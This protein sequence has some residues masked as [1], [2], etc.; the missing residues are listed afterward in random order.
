MSHGTAGARKE[1]G[2]GGIPA[3]RVVE[4][5]PDRRA[6]GHPTG[7][8]RCRRRISPVGRRPIVLGEILRLPRSF[9]FDEVRKATNEVVV[10][11][12]N[13]AGGRRIHVGIRCDPRSRRVDPVVVFVANAVVVHVAGGDLN[14]AAAEDRRVGI[15]QVGE[16]IRRGHRAARYACV[17]ASVLRIGV[18]Q[19]VLVERT[20]E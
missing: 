15:L 11:C 16:G 1:H 8:G 13:A 10:P 4:E 9:G 2:N 19:R 14:E 3:E 7:I 12:A 17:A 18:L 5:R 6:C 20:K